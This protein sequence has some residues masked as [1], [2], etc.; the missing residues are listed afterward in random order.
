LIFQYKVVD[1]D[2]LKSLTI[3]HLQIGPYLIISYG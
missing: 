3:K 2:F 1:G